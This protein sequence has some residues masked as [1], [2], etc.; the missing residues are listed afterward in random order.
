MNN[1][2]MAEQLVKE[3]QSA[4][5]NAHI[6]NELGYIA[7][8]KVR[9]GY[10]APL[11]DESQQRTL[12]DAVRLQGRVTADIVGD[13]MMDIGIEDGDE[14][15]IDTLSRV[16]DGDVVLACSEDEFTVKTLF[17]DANGRRWL[18]PAN[19]QYRPILMT[20]KYEV[21]GRVIRVM[22]RLPHMD[23]NDCLRVL[24]EA[25]NAELRPPTELEVIQAV[26]HVGQRVR[27][28]RQWYSLMRALIDT[29]YLQAG[30]YTRMEELVR[31]FAPLCEHKPNAREL[32]R[33]AVQSFA[34]PIA[35]WDKN[36]APVKGTVFDEYLRLAQESLRMLEK[37][38]VEGLPF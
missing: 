13:S 12:D 14:V 28:G 1:E 37:E 18:L 8:S 2:T 32:S 33:L 3:L 35:C 9:G 30:E 6:T 10:P 24:K 20:G 23:Y 17:T 31:L 27:S 34:K 38:E 11:G 5:W 21:R 4:G 16:R 19:S 7:E 15:I 22:K 36:N 25:G 29:H 26:H